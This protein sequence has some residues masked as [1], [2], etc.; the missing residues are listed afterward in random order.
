[1]FAS[2]KAELSVRRVP[3]NFCTFLIYIFQ[4]AAGKISLTTDLWSDRKLTSFTALTAHFLILDGGVLQPRDAL[5]A[6]HHMKGS[7]DGVALAKVLI[8]MTDRMGITDNVCVYLVL[9]T[10]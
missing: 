6:F 4:L 9:D 1:M 8:E 2:L 10:M 7:H 5:I 3:I